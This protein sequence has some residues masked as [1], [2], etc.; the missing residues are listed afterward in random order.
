MARKSNNA[1]DRRTKLRE[2]LWPG[3][4]VA[5]WTVADEQVVGFATIPRLM[6]WILKLIGDL[7]PKGGNPADVYLELWCRDFGQSI[8]KIEDEQ[9]CAFAAGYDSNRAVRTWK[10]HMQK[11]VNLGFIKA[12]KEHNRDFGQVLLLNPLAVCHKHHKESRVDE[13]WW[14]AFVTRAHNIGADIPDPSVLD[15]DAVAA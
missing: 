2:R 13:E 11:L 1:D 7:S 4:Q 15:F 5:I 12:K 3:S 9:E 14:T 6:P 10:S 8:I